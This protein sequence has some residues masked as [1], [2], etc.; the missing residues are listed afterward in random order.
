[1]APLA[2]PA[3]PHYQVPPP[4]SHNLEWA[5]L[6]IVDLSQVDTPDSRARL[7]RQIRDAM[8][9]TGFFYVINHG[10]TLEQN[11]RVTDIANVAFEQ[12]SL[13]EKQVYVSQPKVTGSYL[14]Y[15][16]Q[17]YW[18]INNGVRD[19]IEL[20]NMNRDLNKRKHPEALRRFLPEIA[21]FARFNH[22]QVLHPILRLMAL[23]LELPENYLVD[24]HNFDSKGE[25]SV[26]F[27]KYYLRTEEDEERSNNVWLKGH[28]DFGSV[29]ILWS[30]PI[31]ALQ[32]LSPDGK[33]RWIKH[34]DNALVINAG[35]CLEFLSGGFYKAT[36]HRVVQP[37][38]DQRQYNRLGAFYF[39]MPDDDVKLNPIMES[40][41]LQREGVHDCFKLHNVET[42]AVEDWRRARTAAYGHNKL[43]TGTQAGTEE[44]VLNGVIVKHYT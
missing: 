9:T 16:L 23:G 11:S 20:Y 39:A 4:T 14:G 8:V 43:T 12:V 44:E 2:L 25:T 21:D 36:I 33:W 30:Q 17:S 6:Q 10:Y 37:P 31:S 3:T 35:D 34:L 18:H 26:R 29:T 40:P 41:V 15:K 32:I 5:Q 24:I 27:M 7:A 22:F 28:T 38:P 13:E 42:V 1:M 19:Q